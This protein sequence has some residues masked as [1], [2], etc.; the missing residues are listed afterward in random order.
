[1]VKRNGLAVFNAFLGVFE[2]MAPVSGINYAD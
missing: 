1:M 2:N